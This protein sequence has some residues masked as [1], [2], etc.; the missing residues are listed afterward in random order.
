MSRK[1]KRLEK[2]D[3]REAW[4]RRHRVLVESYVRDYGDVLPDNADMAL[5]DLA[6]TV[7]LECEKLKVRQLAGATIN[8]DEMVRLA[9]SV[10]RMRKELG[11]KVATIKLAARPKTFRERMKARDVKIAESQ[12]DD[13]IGGTVRP[14]D[15]GQPEPLPADDDGDDEEINLRGGSRNFETAAE[16]MERMSRKRETS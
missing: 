10:T 11:D 3:L 9:N 7:T 2:V 12:D 6:A 15:L 14:S 8:P 16:F 1:S 4:S 5:I 13:E